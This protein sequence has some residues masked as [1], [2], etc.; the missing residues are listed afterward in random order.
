MIIWDFR[1]ILQTEQTFP[2]S[3]RQSRQTSMIAM[4]RSDVTGVVVFL[5]ANP[6]LESQNWKKPK[7][8]NLHKSR[9]NLNLVVDVYMMKIKINKKME[10]IYKMLY[11]FL[12]FNLHLNNNLHSFFN[13]LFKFLYFASFMFRAFSFIVTLAIN[14]N[15]HT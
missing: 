7:L 3:L 6:L 13:K 4:M 8:R 15:I 2:R 5:E 10:I 12:H 1:S 11:N 14:W 9:V